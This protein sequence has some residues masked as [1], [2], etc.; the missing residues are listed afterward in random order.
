MAHYFHDGKRTTKSTRVPAD[1]AGREK[2]Q[3]IADAWETAA[4]M[5]GEGRDGREWMLATLNAIFGAAGLPTAR[6]AVATWETVSAEYLDACRTRRKAAAATMKLYEGTVKSFGEFLGAQRRA[7]VGAITARDVD[8]WVTHLQ[9]RFS[10]G[11]VGTRIQILSGVFNWAV[12]QEFLAR[13]PVARIDRPDSRGLSR[14]PFSHQEV[15]K[16]LAQA[17]HEVNAGVRAAPDR[18]TLLL[19]GL[20]TGARLMDCARMKWENVDL[21]RAQL[22]FLPQKKSRSR[23]MLTLSLVD[24]LLEHLRSMPKVGLF[25]CPHFAKEVGATAVSSDFGFFLDRCGIDRGRVTADRAIGFHAKSFH[26][27]RH[28]L[29]T[30]LAEAGVDDLVRRRITGHDSRQAAAIYQHVSVEATGAAL[31]RV[32]APIQSPRGKTSRP[33]AAR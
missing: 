23:Q 30:W 9:K 24:P 3:A 26:A 13:N 1:E 7:D 29:S 16:M 25:L 21:D 5:A 17:R 32:L 19:L 15:E 20:C 18:L 28:T 27:L 22:T 33:P 31:S 6:Q 8:R 12:R 11:T 10:P 2:A 4:A 14:T